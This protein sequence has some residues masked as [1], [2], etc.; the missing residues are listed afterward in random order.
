MARGRPRRQEGSITPLGDGR[1]LLEW[2]SYITDAETG[3][4]RR[5]HRTLTTE[6]MRKMDAQDRLDEELRKINA[7]PVTRL[8]DDAITLGQW[9]RT[10]YVPMR[11]A[12]WRK[13]TKNTNTYYLEKHIYPRLGHVSLKDLTKYQIQVLLNQLAAEG[14]AYTVLYH[15]RDL[16]KAA[17]SEAVEQEVLGKNVANKTF[18]PEIEPRER[19]VLPVDM[20]PK[21]LGRLE[22]PRDRAIFSVGSFCALRP[23]ELFGLLWEDYQGDH[24]RVSNTAYH[25]ELQRKKIK[26]RRLNGTENY[27]VVPIPA[28]VREIMEEWRRASPNNAPEAV[29][30][31]GTRGRGR[32]VLSKPMHPDNWLRL[33]LHNI[34]EELKIGFHVT[35]QVLRRS[36][37]THAQ[38]TMKPKSMQAMYGHSDIRT[39]MDIYTQTVEPEVMKSANAVTDMLLGIDAK[40]ISGKA[41]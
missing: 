40:P 17:L 20:Y 39:T 14:Y 30:F 36:F 26:K 16:I 35:F 3:K 32:K 29:I 8:A 22:A 7:G 18:I 28:R 13:A 5:V 34:A 31:P 19:P 23:S 12:N 10:V 21:I 41:Q 2:H 6:K 15:V 1:W 37:G 33:H 25:G 11:E 24:F 9:L 38:E 27:R 4:E